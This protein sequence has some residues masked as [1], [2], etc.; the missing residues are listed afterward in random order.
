MS[1]GVKRAAGRYSEFD[2][3]LLILAC[4]AKNVHRRWSDALDSQSVGCLNRGAGRHST[5]PAATSDTACI[6]CEEGRHSAVIVYQILLGV[7]HARKGFS[8]LGAGLHFVFHVFLVSIKI[9]KGKTCKLC[10]VNEFANE[11]EMIRCCSSVGTVA[12]S[13]GSA[14]CSACAAGEFGELTE[15]GGPACSKCQAGR[16][17]RGDSESLVS[18]ETCPAGFYQSSEGQAACL[19]CVPGKYQDEKN[20]SSCKLCPVNEF[21]NETEMTRCHTCRIGM[22]ARDAGSA[23]CQA[24]IAG[25]Y[26][27]S[28]SLCPSGRYRAGDD[29]DITQCKACPAGFN[30]PETGTTYCLGCEAGRYADRPAQ[31]DCTQCPVNTIVPEKR[32]TSA[33]VCEP[34]TITGPYP[35]TSS[36]GA[37]NP[38]STD[39]TAFPG[40]ASGG[41]RG[42]FT[43]MMGLTFNHRRPSLFVLCPSHATRPR[44]VRAE[45]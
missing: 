8:S 31:A 41:Q 19:P 16:F 15:A 34:C 23:V 22:V 7:V 13:Q 27:Q 6:G 14:A 43:S 20:G 24:C 4:H 42:R 40:S 35:T 5:L 44:A 18:C 1:Q 28:C 37:S 3:L 9:K 17:R 45:L 39:S 2:A 30:Q 11:T 26:G 38:W 29:N 21:A 25:T 33:A 36:Q 10:P 12:T 32:S